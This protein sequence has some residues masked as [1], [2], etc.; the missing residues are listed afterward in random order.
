MAGFA[1]AGLEMFASVSLIF[2]C[3]IQF[4]SWFLKSYLNSPFIVEWRCR[5]TKCA[6]SDQ[7]FNPQAS[8]EFSHDA[9]KKIV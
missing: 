1:P 8:K 2:M 6:R 9:G 7:I 5:S 3:F 4:L